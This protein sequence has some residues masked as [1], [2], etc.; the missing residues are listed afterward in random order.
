LTFDFVWGNQLLADFVN[1]REWFLKVLVDSLVS[2]QFKFLLQRIL[3]VFG[4]LR[5]DLYL[6]QEAVLFVVFEIFLAYITIGIIVDIVVL[7][8]NLISDCKG[9]F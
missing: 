3:V 9:F 7:H 8:P 6:N 1:F 4:L 2:D 5:N